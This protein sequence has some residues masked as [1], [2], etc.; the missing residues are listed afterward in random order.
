MLNALQIKTRNLHE[1]CN[2]L[3]SNNQSLWCELHQLNLHLNERIAKLP[4]QTQELLTDY[5]RLKTQFL[6]RQATIEATIEDLSA[7]VARLTE[8]GTA[9]A[10][11]IQRW[12]DGTLPPSAQE[13]STPPVSKFRTTPSPKSEASVSWSIDNQST[14][15]RSGLFAVKTKP[16]VPETAFIAISKPKSGGR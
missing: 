2:W 3:I 4:E 8:A 12:L 7:K 15:N 6:D 14:A 1:Q 13:S 11:P 9:S 10:N 5:N 16:R